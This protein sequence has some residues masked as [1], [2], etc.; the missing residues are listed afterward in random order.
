MNSR[1]RMRLH[2]VQTL[3]LW[4]DNFELHASDVEHMFDADFVRMWRLYLNG[5]IASF[6]AGGLQLF[7]V[8]FAHGQN[9]LLPWTRADVYTELQHV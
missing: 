4:R 8:V 2:Y 9:N 1:S 7:Q 3:E 5:S 6:R